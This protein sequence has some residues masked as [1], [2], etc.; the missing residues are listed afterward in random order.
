[1][2]LPAYDHLRGLVHSQKEI[3]AERRQEQVLLM[4]VY[5]ST[6]AKRSIAMP[7]S[8]RLGTIAGIEIDIN[9]SWIVIIVLLTVSLATGWFHQLYPGW[10]PATYV[11]P[12]KVSMKFW[13]IPV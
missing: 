11:T 1:M 5:L 10:S 13:N 9:I 3:C 4:C 8:F 7:G 6:C 2:T 12:K